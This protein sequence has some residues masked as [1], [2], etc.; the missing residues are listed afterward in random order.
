MGHEG[1]F[2]EYEVDYVEQLKEIAQVRLDNCVS[3]ANQSATWQDRCRRAEQEA[4]A[5]GRVAQDYSDWY[6]EAW[7]L[8]DR[9]IPLMKWH[10]DYEDGDHIYTPEQ[11]ALLNEIEEKRKPQ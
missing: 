2:Q 6:H 11:V 7:D 5:V 4:K 10:E 1:Q 3:M 9:L 8:I